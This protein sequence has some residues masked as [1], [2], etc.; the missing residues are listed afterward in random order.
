MV[1]SVTAT[2]IS[3]S[4]TSGGEGVDYKVMWQRDT[5]LEC[6]DV[7]EGSINIT[8]GST[9]Y[10]IA[11]LQENSSYSITVTASSG[12]DNS[13]ISNSVTAITLEA[14]ERYK[15]I[16]IVVLLGSMCF[17]NLQHLLLPLLL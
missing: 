5:S 3:L 10:T 15:A 17:Y 9:S 14:G 1:G 13:E 11:G 12:E 6:P 8:N 7:D 4:W 16:A 2:S